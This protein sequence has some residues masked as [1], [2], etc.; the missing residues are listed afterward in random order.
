L[1]VLYTCDGKNVPPQLTWTHPAKEAQSLILIMSSSDAKSEQKYHWVLH[2]IPPTT[3]ELPELM[4]KLPHGAKLAKNSW[5]SADYQSPCPER[6][7]VQSYIFTL[8]VLNK[9]VDI[10]PDTTPEQI[11]D[12][13]KNNIIQTGNI[14]AVYSRWPVA[15]N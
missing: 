14:T 1:P 10:K 7:D 2:N 13:I 5:G 3:T 4:S 15:L 12:Q 8:Y 11:L 9:K 6:G